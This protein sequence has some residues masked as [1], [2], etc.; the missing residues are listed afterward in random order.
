MSQS[1]SSCQVSKSNRNHP[2][3]APPPP[4]V[5]GVPPTSG[6]PRSRQHISDG[7]LD[8]LRG[9]PYGRDPASTSI[10]TPETDTAIKSQAQNPSRIPTPAFHQVVTNFIDTSLGG[11]FSSPA[12][13][14]RSVGKTPA[15]GTDSGVLLGSSL[16][17]HPTGSPVSSASGSAGNSR[18]RFTSK[19]RIG[20]ASPSVSPSVLQG[21]VLSHA[22]YQAT[23]PP[24]CSVSF[25]GACVNTA[26]PN[27]FHLQHWIPRHDP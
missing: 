19:L 24:T 27:M 16:S 9:S 22:V 17:L 25:Q 26:W 2:P 13:T 21:P 10:S 11:S 15:G 8:P 1:I 14:G 7:N 20:K 12:L 18:F 3:Q 6:A 23:H 5:Q 4:P